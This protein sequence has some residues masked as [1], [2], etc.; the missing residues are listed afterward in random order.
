MAALK[1]LIK[2]NSYN[3]IGEEERSAVDEVMRS[4]LSNYWCM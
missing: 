3:S 2:I 1:Q 4:V